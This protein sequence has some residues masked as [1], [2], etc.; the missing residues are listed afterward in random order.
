MIRRARAAALLA[1]VAAVAA[2]CTSNPAQDAADGALGFYQDVLGRQWAWHCNFQPGCST[3]ARQAVAQQGAIR[4]VVMAADR[5]Q[6]DHTMQRDEY[7][8]DEYGRPIDPPA[9]SALFGPRIEEEA[10]EQDEALAQALA[11]APPLTLDDAQ[12][13]GFADRYWDAREWERARIEYERLLFARP[14]SPLA[15]HCRTRA[16]LCLAKARRRGDAL[17]HVEKI[18]AP[19]E[20]ERTRALVEREIE[21]PAAAL[22][23]AEMGDSP[24]LA[25]FLA[26]EAERTDAAREQFARV[27]AP[28]RDELLRCAD[29][30]DALPRK[31]PALAG[32]MSALLPGSGQLYVGRP[33]DALAAFSINAVLIGGTVLAA[34]RDQDAAAIAIG[35]VASGFWFGNIYGAANGA[36]LDAKE[37]RDHRLDQARGHL[38]QSGFFATLDQDQR[39]GAIG[40]YFGL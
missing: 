38:R 7:P 19:A 11:D 36:A 14:G 10:R 35:F 16:A 1:A 15:D 13:A 12:Q 9:A 39:G 6:R 20:R 30:V 4:G 2:G 27:G 22:R 8:H 25:G 33:G 24:L 37:R 17:A 34:R 32:T 31:S 40:I 23:A 3:F 28:A 21:R 26:L 5:L 29:D 18:A